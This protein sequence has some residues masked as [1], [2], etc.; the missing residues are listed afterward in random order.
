MISIYVNLLMKL[1]FVGW[2]LWCSTRAQSLRS[3][4]LFLTL[5][6]LEAVSFGFSSSAALYPNLSYL[7]HSP[8]LIALNWLAALLVV[9][10]IFTAAR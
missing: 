3:R 5:A 4:V 6:T 10:A 1:I 2:V 9:P 8:V 7:L